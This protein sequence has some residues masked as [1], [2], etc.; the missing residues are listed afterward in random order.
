MENWGMK[1]SRSKNVLTAKNNELILNSALNVLKRQTSFLQGKKSLTIGPNTNATLTITH[2]LGY[3]PVCFA[4]FEADNSLWHPVDMDIRS[5][6]LA[7]VFGGT[8][9]NIYINKDNMY[10]N[11]TNS[12]G[13]SKTV[14]IFYIMFLNPLYG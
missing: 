2:S 4:W 9:S 5:N 6:D 1:I 13:T 10:V 14:P 12:S 11:L 3:I 8:N 7:T